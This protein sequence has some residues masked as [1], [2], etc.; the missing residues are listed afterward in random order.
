MLH[1]TSRIRTGGT[2][3]NNVE[4]EDNFEEQEEQLEEKYDQDRIFR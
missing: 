4:S 3:S 1:L 2:L